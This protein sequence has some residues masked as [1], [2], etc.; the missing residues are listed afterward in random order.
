M[1][2]VRFVMVSE[3]MK[4]GSIN[5]FVRADPGADRLELVRFLFTTFSLLI[6]DGYMT[7]VA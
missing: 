2:E 5:E 6:T 4:R 3:W 1:A 7:I